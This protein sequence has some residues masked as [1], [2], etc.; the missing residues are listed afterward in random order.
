M[1]CVDLSV[2]IGALVS[3]LGQASMQFNNI[4]MQRMDVLTGTDALERKRKSI[5]AL[6]LETFK[7]KTVKKIVLVLNCEDFSS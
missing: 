2:S 1:N 5:F 3:A 7:M 6:T 4:Q